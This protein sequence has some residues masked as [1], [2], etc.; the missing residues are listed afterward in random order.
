MAQ[1][2]A[3][4]SKRFDEAFD[5]RYAEIIGARHAESVSWRLI[6]FWHLCGDA[7]AIVSRI[8]ALEEVGVSTVSMTIYTVLDALPL[9]P[10]RG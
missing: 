1:A 2:L 10:G 3:A 4:D 9:I 6:D 5:I 7:D 8:D